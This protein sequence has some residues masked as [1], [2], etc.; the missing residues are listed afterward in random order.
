MKEFMRSVALKF[1]KKIAIKNVANCPMQ[2]SMILRCYVIDMS[3]SSNKIFFTFYTWSR[4]SSHRVTRHTYRGTCVE[5]RRLALTQSTWFREYAGSWVRRATSNTISVNDYV[6]PRGNRLNRW[7]NSGARKV[8]C[9]IGKVIAHIFHRI[10]IEKRKKRH[11]SSSNH[12][13]TLFTNGEISNCELLFLIKKKP[14]VFFNLCL[15]SY[16]S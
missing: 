1:T 7:L 2:I 16:V 4:S 12:V 11:D 10:R 8:S 6:I 5:K 3:F 9:A 15:P 13:S 14:S